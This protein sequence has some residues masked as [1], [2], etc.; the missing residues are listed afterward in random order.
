[1]LYVSSGTK[2]T[3]G[4]FAVGVL[5]GKLIDGGLANILAVESLRHGTNF[6][7][8]VSL[9][10]FGG[11]PNWGGT[12]I[13][14]TNGFFYDPD[15]KRHFYVFRDT[16]YKHF[17]FNDPALSSIKERIL[18]LFGKWAFP[19]LHIFLSG[20]NLC[21]NTLGLPQDST[22][23][24]VKRI[25]Y[26][27]SLVGGLVSLAITPTIKF[28]VDRIDPKRF[29]DD[30]RY[31]ES[32]YMTPQK[33]EA[34]R[35]GIMGS[36]LTGVNFRWFQRAAA[37]PL[38]PVVGIMQL[39]AGVGLAR[40]VTQFASKTALAPVQMLVPCALGFLLS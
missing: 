29:L 14:S 23:C 12:K 7:S 27:T 3:L 31:Y 9:R 21:S 34:W 15:V 10:F 2:V 39:T 17:R 26:G 33:L 20:A 22:N 32:A 5:W 18:A 28:R 38:K 35:I 25:R 40:F 13:G 30:P 6:F 4:C 1:M 36:L 11:D 19:K 37:H 24:L 8:S 16:E